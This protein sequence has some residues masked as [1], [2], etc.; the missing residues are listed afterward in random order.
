M[1]P[2]YNLAQGSPCPLRFHM[3]AEGAFDLGCGS[4]CLIAAGLVALGAPL[5]AGI[6]L[7]IGGPLSTLLL[8]R[9]HYAEPAVSS[10][11]TPSR[12]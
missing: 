5:S 11:T 2:V 8:L 6:L 4:A 10:L 12:S 7:A 1:T 3:A 9:R